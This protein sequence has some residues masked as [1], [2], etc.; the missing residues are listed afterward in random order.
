MADDVLTEARTRAVD[1]VSL[2]ELDEV[3]GLVIVQLVVGDETELHGRGRHAFLEIRRVEAEPAAEVLDDVV[4]AG[5][6][7]RLGGHPPRIPRR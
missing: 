7:V 6:V 5:H 3:G 2:D 4:L 1:P